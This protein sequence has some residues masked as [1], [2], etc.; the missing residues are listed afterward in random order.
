MRE[1]KADILIVGGGVG[2]CAAAMAATAMGCSVILS[3]PTHWLGGQL[4]SQA[5][6]PD[7]HP[8]IEHCGGTARYRQFRQ[9]VRDYYRAHYPLVKQS[10]DDP[11]LNPG[12]G[13]VGA[14]C[15]EP[16]V[17]C[18]V[19]DQMLAFARSNG[20]LRVLFRHE[21]VEVGVEGDC[22]RGVIL[23]DM[24][25]DESVVVTA[26]YVLDATELGDL[27]PLADVAYVSGAESQDDTGEPHAVAGPAQP[28]N[29]QAL[30]WCFPLAFDP[31]PGAE[32]V[33]DRPRQ[34]EHWRDDIPRLTPA[35][36]GSL[37]SWDA[38]SPLTLEHRRFELFGDVSRP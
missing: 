5:V 19:I 28:K 6:P 21:P 1:M 25:R 16:R 31:A 13:T 36:S 35:W 38:V 18:A 26:Q 14:L 27:L 37:L 23:R 7:E 17:A 12:K 10:L 20:H 32:H 33:I 8:W 34:Y 9:G 30:T 29:V 22:V 11:F 4:T 3:E 2:G 15:H 24:D